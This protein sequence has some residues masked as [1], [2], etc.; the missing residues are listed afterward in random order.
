MRHLY[1]GNLEGVPASRGYFCGVEWSLRQITVVRCPYGLC[2]S[3]TYCHTKKNHSKQADIQ[4]TKY[5]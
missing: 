4:K 5:L 2:E 1:K 3:T